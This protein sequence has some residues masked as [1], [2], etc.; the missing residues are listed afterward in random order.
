MTTFSRDQCIA[1]L[2]ACNAWTSK[3][4]HLQWTDAQLEA[5]ICNRRRTG[6]ISDEMLVRTLNDTHEAT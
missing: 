2:K 5:M 4:D 1:L 3:D 6:V